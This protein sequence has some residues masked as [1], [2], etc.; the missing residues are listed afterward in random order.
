MNSNRDTRPLVPGDPA[1]PD[2]SSGYGNGGAGGAKNTR[3]RHGYHP[4]KRR[5]LAL[6]THNVHTLRLDEKLVELEEEMDKLRWD[7]VRL[8][9]IR[10]QGE[11]TIT[12]QSS[13]LFF[14][15]VG[16]QKSY[17][18][19]LPQTHADDEGEG[20]YEDVSR[21]LHSSK[22]HFTVVIGDFNATLGCTSND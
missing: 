15:R 21:V 8:S 17:R 5:P 13:H 4:Q 10:R 16:E 6:V 12:L 19:T 20:L 22:I 18:F 2:Y 9:E 14:Y 3:Q 7:I 1:I 11:D